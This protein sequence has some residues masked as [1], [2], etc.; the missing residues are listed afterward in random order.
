MSVPPPM[1]AV[2][3]PVIQA[4][5]VDQSQQ[6]TQ[7]TLQ[8]VTSQQPTILQQQT[9]IP[10]NMPIHLHQSPFHYHEEILHGG[11][12]KQQVTGQVQANV[13]IP[14]PNIHTIPVKQGPLH[15][16][17]P[18]LSQPPPNIQLQQPQATQIVLNQ[19]ASNYQ[20][21]YI[22]QQQVNDQQQVTIQHIYQ[23][24]GIVQTTTQP[25]THLN[26]FATQ[27]LRPPQS[28]Q[29]IVQGTTY[30]VPP[31]NIIQHQ[32]PPVAQAQ[33]PQ[34]NI[35][36]QTAP[37]QPGQLLQQIQ[38]QPPP[39]IVDTTT[40]ANDDAIKDEKLPPS[41]LSEGAIKTEDGGGGA[42]GNASPNSQQL[43]QQMQ[44][45]PPT[46]SLRDPQRDRTFRYEPPTIST[47]T[48][49]PPPIMAVPPPPPPMI[50]VGNT[51]IATSQ[52]AGQ[53]QQIQYNQP[54]SI[55]QI[56]A[57]P[58]QIHVS[59]QNG[60]HFLVNQQQWPP[61]QHQFQQH[62]FQLTTPQPQTII[63]PQHGHPLDAAA[64]VP[65]CQTATSVHLIEPGTFERSETCER[66]FRAQFR[67][68]VSVA[69]HT[70]PPSHQHIL[71]TAF[72]PHIPAPTV[73]GMMQ[74]Q[75]QPLQQQQV[76]MQLHRIAAQ[77]DIQLH[78]ITSQDGVQQTVRTETHV[79][80][81][82]IKMNLPSY[83]PQV[84]SPQP[85]PYPTTVNARLIVSH[86]ST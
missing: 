76:G 4:N 69:N 60:Q 24:Q 56:Q 31:P 5:T 75:L 82:Q 84:T 1:L 55:Q 32:P 13:S 9:I 25:A 83:P 70:K 19:P 21:Q 43:S 40:A 26:Q 68:P 29:Y 65:Q 44:Q 85:V 39:N 77:D 73:T 48:Q 15:I 50:I 53:T 81:S 33:A 12:A 52:A 27:T 2:P 71:T 54:L 17:G 47:V 37:P 36:F 46:V 18:P 74:V 72:N 6:P 22:Q 58:Q 86:K 64:S 42:D 67:A 49:V 3:P 28:Q 30:M 10:P 45:P 62:Q 78:Q 14:P 51:L 20:Y 16:Q 11:G 57:P 38:F 41:D 80:D 23:P 35:I 59:T 7:A 61:Q 66:R 79:V 34:Q 8:T 63:T